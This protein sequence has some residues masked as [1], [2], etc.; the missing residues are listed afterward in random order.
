[1]ALLVDIHAAQGI[2][3][4]ILSLGEN[5]HEC[6]LRMEGSQVLHQCL[7]VVECDGRIGCADIAL[8][9][10]AVDRSLAFSVILYGGILDCCWIIILH[11]IVNK[12][13]DSVALIDMFG[14]ICQFPLV[15]AS[16]Q[17]TYLSILV[18]S[19]QPGHPWEPP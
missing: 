15:F 4:A 13:T 2:F 10:K 16:E 14:Y 19:R 17:G 5:C 11:E 7:R 3:H 8:D 12:A 1:M 18:L 9:A 6:R